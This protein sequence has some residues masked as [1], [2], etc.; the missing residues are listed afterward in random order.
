MCDHSCTAQLHVRSVESATATMSRSRRA[1]S[2]TLGSRYGPPSNLSEFRQI[3]TF[4]RRTPWPR[5]RAPRRR[6]L[7]TGEPLLTERLDLLGAQLGR[8]DAR[9]CHAQLL[10]RDE[11]EGGEQ[12]RDRRFQR[13]RLYHRGPRVG[14][15]VEQIIWPLG[16]PGGENESTSVM[17]MHR[18]SGQR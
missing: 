17:R 6:A 10:D 9:S 2:C 7:P 8:E 14:E 5:Q 4:P 12:D 18:L 13:D 3:A 1:L 16:R 15:L 11:R